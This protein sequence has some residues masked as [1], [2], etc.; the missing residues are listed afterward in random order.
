MNLG[1]VRKA[2][3][4]AFALVVVAVAVGTLVPGGGRWLP[5]DA[6][7]ATHLAAFTLTGMLAR[8]AMPEV[9]W[10]ISAALVLAVA[11]GVAAESLQLLVPGR[12]FSLTDLSTNLAGSVA[13]VLLA[14]LVLFVVTRMRLDAADK[15][16]AAEPD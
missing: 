10:A 2:S 16:K 11:L 14:Q 13:G 1:R 7:L 12:T 15:G 9:R 5:F 4:L 6:P 3:L 8:F